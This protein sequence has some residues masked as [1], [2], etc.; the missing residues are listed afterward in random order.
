MKNKWKSIRLGAM[1]FALPIVATAAASAN[2]WMIEN[3]PIVTSSDI[4]TTFDSINVKRNH[5]IALNDSGNVEGRL[6]T[7]ESDSRAVSYTHLTLP[8]IYSV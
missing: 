2:Q 5:T 8:T 7:I 3:A 6:A 1:L 4:A